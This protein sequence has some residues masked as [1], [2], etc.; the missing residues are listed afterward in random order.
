MTVATK[1]PFWQRINPF[2]R[3]KRAIDLYGGERVNLLTEQLSTPE[4]RRLFRSNADVVAIYGAVFAAIRRRS[5]AVA[6]PRVVLVQGRGDDEVEVDSHPALDAL[7]RVNESLTRQQGFGLIEQHKL[8]HGKAYWV[9]RRDGLQTPVEFEIWPPDRVKPVA[10]EKKPWVPM[11]FEYHKSL[12]TVERVGREDVVWFRHMVDPRNPLDGV[13][14]IGAVRTQIDTGI[15]AERFNQRYLDNFLSIGAMFS[16]EDISQAEADR[17]TQELERKFK[18]TDKAGRAFVSSG[19]LKSLDTKPPHKDM[20][21]VLQQ[22]WGVEEVARVMEMDP[23]LLG[24]GSRTYENAPAAERSF[25]AMIV[26]QVDATLAEFNEFFLWPDFGEEFR[27]VAR[28]DNIEALQVDKK[29]RA[30]VDKIHLETG[31]RY[32]NELRERDGE[33]SVAW[34]EVP[35]MPLGTV[36]L[37]QIPTV[38]TPEQLKEAVEIAPVEGPMSAWITVNGERMYVGPRAV[39]VEPLEDGWNQRL[40]LELEALVKHFE[41]ADARAFE[42]ADVN[43]YDWDWWAKYG[44]DVVGEFE[45]LYTGVLASAGFVESPMMGAQ[46][47][48]AR[49]AKGRG[50]ELLRL[51]GRTNVVNATRNWVRNLVSDTIESGGTIQSLTKALRSNFAFSRDRAGMIAVTETATAQTKGSL[52]SYQSQGTEGKEWQTAGDER[53]CEICAGAEG[54]GAIPVGTPFNNGL[55]GPPGHPRCRCTV[56]PVRELPRD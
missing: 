50:A 2:R 5:R 30:E 51:E 24:L 23:E 41:A 3:E 28:Y 37:G 48:A 6:K 27:F 43:S 21:F 55:D 26:D 56:L 8:T 36:P 29:A 39:S 15:E 18:G 45:V 19:G 13:S 47:L 22:K 38:S 16:G 7:N 17:V 12:G 14:P 9:K 42:A 34:G 49:W 32:I 33:E 44:D 4:A 1:P 11:Y 53:V 10:D 54:D 52:A 40:T 31:A 46:E 25:W 20:E 35:L